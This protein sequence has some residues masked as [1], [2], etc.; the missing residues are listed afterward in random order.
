MTK[1]TKSSII[2]KIYNLTNIMG[3]NSTSKFV[4][5]TVMSWLALWIV[6]AKNKSYEAVNEVL[7]NWTILVEDKNQNNYKST[8][9]DLSWELKKD[10]VQPINYKL[11]QLIKNT[12]LKVADNWNV[13]L[14]EF[15][16][17]STK[18]FWSI[19]KRPFKLDDVMA[20]DVYKQTVKEGDNY[21]I[22]EYS[23]KFEEYLPKKNFK[24][25]AKLATGSRK[26][27]E[28]KAWKLD[29]TWEQIH[30]YGVMDANLDYFKNMFQ[31]LLF[32]NG[33]DIHFNNKDKKTVDVIK[34]PV[35][36]F[37]SLIYTLS[38]KDW[39]AVKE[40]ESL[41][42]ILEKY[43]SKWLVVNEWIKYGIYGMKIMAEQADWAREKF[44]TADVTTVDKVKLDRIKE[45]KEQL[46]WSN[47]E[48]ERLKAK[49]KILK[50]EWE[51]LNARLERLNARLMKTKAEN[52]V[53]RVIIN[54]LKWL[55]SV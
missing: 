8:L 42:R 12:D 49:L 23:P 51:R 4:I 22:W 38:Y 20:W 47:L 27:K 40:Q 32:E 33:K 25:L 39:P 48:W 9:S 45:L 41:L 31:A 14:K 30:K 2:N 15:V 50:A 13:W 55:K 36:R 28:Y 44:F 54:S 11:D 7:D 3:L 5:A 19:S 37:I 29:L 46:K 35:K 21:I 34:L 17:Q 10:I 18:D 53:L 16:N 52:E 24:E 43:E 26:Y 6:E 1:H